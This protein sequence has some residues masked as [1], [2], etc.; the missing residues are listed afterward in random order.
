MEQPARPH[1]LR[2]RALASI[3]RANVRVHVTT[4]AGPK[5]QAAHQHGGHRL[6]PAEM[7]PERRVVRKKKSMVAA[8]PLFELSAE[9]VTFS[10][11]QE[12]TTFFYFLFFYF[13]S[14]RFSFLS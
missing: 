3:A 4:L 8:S 1:V 11:S 14:A 13:I 2:F 5:C 10:F 12:T 6:M 9:H 7:S